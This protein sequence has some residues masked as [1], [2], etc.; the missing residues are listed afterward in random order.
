MKDITKRRKAEEE[1][2]LQKTYFEK[3]F[4]SAPEAITLQDNNDFIVDVNDEFT[5]LFDFLLQNARAMALDIDDESGGD[6]LTQIKMILSKAVGAYHSLCA[7]GK[8]YVNHHNQVS[9]VV[10]WN[11]GE[12]GH[13]CG[14]CNMPKDQSKID[15]AHK[16]W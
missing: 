5:K 16:E 6:T 7:A 4:N 8:W 10:C 3:L 14:K 15:A 1:L 11:C 13:I 12:E 2:H 9:L